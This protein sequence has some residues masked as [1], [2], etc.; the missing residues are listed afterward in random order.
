MS[1]QQTEEIYGF[2]PVKAVAE[3][4]APELPYKPRSPK[5]YN[6]NIGLIACGNI[7][8]QHLRAYRKAGFNVV[9][10]C[11]LVLARAEKRRDEFYPDACVCTDYRDVL[12]RDDIEVVDIATHPIEREP[13]IP[14]ALRARKHVLSHKPFVLDLDLGQQFVE[15][16][17]EMG[18]KLAVNQNGR[19]APHFSYI[20]HAIEAGLLGDVATASFELHFDH[21]WTATTPFNNLHHLALYDYAVHWFDATQTFFAGRPA[22][23]VFA[24]IGR[25]KTQKSTPP[26]LAHV[27]ID[28]DDGQATMT[29]NGDT[30]YGPQDSTT[31]IGGKGTLRSIGPDLLDQRVTLT[32][33]QG[34]AHPR[35]EGRWWPDGM[36]G[37]MGE[38]LCAIEEDR[39]PRNSARN[40][41]RSLEICFAAIASADSGQPVIP[42]DSRRLPDTCITRSRLD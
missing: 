36:H 40:N 4:P 25:S 31:V 7:T 5:R 9:A 15:L 35:L 37:T 13:I 12:A 8:E 41:L 14:D 16:A 17:D 34:V 27:T 2:T 10:L 1:E 18:V 22:R 32:T 33:E 24:S 11:D 38:L 29:L 19:W 21:N 30:V 3:I 20:R 26:L 39:E 23:K 6:P 42:G 28:F